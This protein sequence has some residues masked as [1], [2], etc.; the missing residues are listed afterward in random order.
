MTILVFLFLSFFSPQSDQQNSAKLEHLVNERQSLHQQWQDSESKKS[1]IFGNRTKKDMKETNDWLARIIAK[2][3]QIIEELKLSGKI[4]TA[5]IGQ[6]K[7]DY[8]TITLSLE[9]DV[10]ALKRALAK[11]DKSIETMKSTRRT[12]EWTTLIFFL[13]TLGLGY[14][15][16][17]MKKGA[18]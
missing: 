5:V 16:Y 3:N 11:R 18:K 13:T 12:F 2:D 7:D 17:R 10:Q 14:G 1:G 8:K 15:I 6:E 9:Q 4:E